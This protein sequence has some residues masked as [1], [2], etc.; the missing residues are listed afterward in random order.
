MPPDRRPDLSWDPLPHTHFKFLLDR[1]CKRAERYEHFFSLAI[2]RFEQTEFNTSLLNSVTGLIRNVIRESDM[3]GALQDKDL[4]II[5]QYAEDVSMTPIVI[6]INSALQ[7]GQISCCKIKIGW[8]G[9]PTDATTS[10]D[11]L[12][13]ARESQGMNLKFG[14]D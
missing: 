5:L 9:F 3:I 1:E 6:R 12:R 13:M 7:R 2:V 10:E 4:A 8:A 14:T 11:L